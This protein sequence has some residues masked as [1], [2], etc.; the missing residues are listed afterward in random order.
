MAPSVLNDTPFGGGSTSATTTGAITI[1]ATAAGSLLVVLV[2]MGTASTP[3]TSVSSIS[4]GGGTWAQTPGHD[5]S[6]TRKD[7]AEIWWTAPNAATTSVTVNFAATCGYGGHILEL[8]GCITASPVDVGGGTNGSSTA[9]VTPNAVTTVPAEVLCAI[10]NQ[11][12]STVTVSSPTAGWTVD[13]Q[14]T[15]HPTSIAAMTNCAYQVVSVTGTY[16]FGLTL[17]A[18]AIWS[19]CI[20]TFK[21]AVAGPLPIP[22]V[23]QAVVR[24]AVW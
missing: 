10:I 7:S 3:S 22:R 17:S 12:T 11:G 23:S 21:G 13:A 6:S 20:A 9:P 16:S 19:A 14:Q 18:S 2:G 1:P 24:A 15:N 4:G 8:G 5:N